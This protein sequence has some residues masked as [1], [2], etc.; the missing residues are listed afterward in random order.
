MNIHETI[1]FLK[2]KGRNVVYITSVDRELEIT[3]LAYEHREDILV[4]Q[5][6]DSNY[7]CVTNILSSRKDLYV[8]M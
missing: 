3:R 8:F 2:S 7:K 1:N 4:F 5:P 6:N